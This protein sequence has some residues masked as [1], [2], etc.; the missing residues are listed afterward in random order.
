MKLA[1][2]GF[3]P[4]ALGY[5]FG[6]NEPSVIR[7]IDELAE[8]GRGWHF[9]EGTA[10][11]S[12][13][14]AVAKTVAS[15]ATSRNLAELD[16]FPGK[17]GEVTIVIYVGEKDHSFQVGRDLSYSYWVES[18]PETETEEGLSFKDVLEKIDAIAEAPANPPW[19]L[20]SSFIYVTTTAASD[21]FGARPSET[22]AMEAEYP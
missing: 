14:L 17:N 9:G 13:V 19:N 11:S 22:Q 20:F 15:Y 5:Y 12:T 10:L 6:Y 8:L 1:E 16:A 4:R 3:N 18:N 21:I 2:F 7:R